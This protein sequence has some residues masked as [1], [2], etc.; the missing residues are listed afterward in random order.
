MH[1]LLTFL[2]YIKAGKLIVKTLNFR[3]DFHRSFLVCTD[4]QTLKAG[5]GINNSQ[6]ID[7]VR[8]NVI[9]V[10]RQSSLSRQR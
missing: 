5:R 2:F 4:F 1:C 3:R 9:L 8:L 10:W 6:K 7:D